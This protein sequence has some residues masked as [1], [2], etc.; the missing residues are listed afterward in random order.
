MSKAGNTNTNADALSRKPIPTLAVSTRSMTRAPPCKT[1]TQPS[2]TPQPTPP[3]TQKLSPPRDEDESCD[4]ESIIY[5]TSGIEAQR[6]IVYV[7]DRLVM[8]Q[9]N[10]ACL[11]AQDG[12]PVDP[13]TED[14]ARQGKL[15]TG[16]D[17][18]LGRVKVT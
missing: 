15:P 12:S 5:D 2:E 16:I 9:D 4:E 8:R 6:T 18:V 10:L 17:L 14:L 3:A 13:G 11:V 7:R 1:P